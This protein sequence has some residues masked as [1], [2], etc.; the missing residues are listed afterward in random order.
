MHVN[1]PTLL[2]I[3]IVDTWYA[4]SQCM[5]TQEKQKVLYSLLAEEL[6]D[7]KYNTVGSGGSG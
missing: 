2:G 7:N 5:D 6:I 3:C 4:N 1:T